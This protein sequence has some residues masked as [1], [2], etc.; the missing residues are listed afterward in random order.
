MARKCH[1]FHHSPNVT[2]ELLRFGLASGDPPFS[3]SKPELAHPRTTALANK[4]EVSHRARRGQRGVEIVEFAF[5][6]PIFMGI[7]LALIWFGMAYNRYETITRAAREGARFAVAP[8]CAT[9]SPANTPPTDAEVITRVQNTLQVD[10]LK[11][12]RVTAYAWP[13]TTPPGS[14]ATDGTSHIT[15]CRGVQLDNGS[16]TGTAQFGIVVSFGYP[17]EFPVS[18]NTSAS[19][20][21]VGLPQLTLKANAQMFQEQ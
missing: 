14:C 3:C 17:V 16:T 5:V 2:L 4:I 13:G 8:S 19:G 9:C 7:L 6:L 11:P 1:S 20:K 12:S 21:V 15:I 18:M 10:G